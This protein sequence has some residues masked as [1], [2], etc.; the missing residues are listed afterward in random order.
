MHLY[1]PV[2]YSAAASLCC[3]PAVIDAAASCSAVVRCC[4]SS[5][6]AGLFNFFFRWFH[7]PDKRNK[8]ILEHPGAMTSHIRCEAPTV[9]HC[10]VSDVVWSLMVVV[11]H[12]RNL[13]AK[14][15]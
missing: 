2:M 15:A 6:C 12:D 14:L 5:S 7:A 11:H 13:W 8:D 4:S 1:T 9:I 10:S 3:Y